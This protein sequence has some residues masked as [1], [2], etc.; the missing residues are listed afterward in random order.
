[1]HSLEKKNAELTDAKERALSA[2]RMKDLFIQNMSH[3]IRTPLNSI[4]GFSQLLATPDMELSPEEQQEY[5]RLITCNSE[6]L[7]TLVNDI[8]GVAELESGN[9]SIHMDRVRCNELCRN[10]LVTVSHRKPAGVELTFT[11]EADDGYTLHTDGKRVSQVLINFLT[12]AEKHTVKGTIGLH[13]SLSERPGSITFSVSDTGCG[14]PPEEAEHIFERFRKLD[15]FQQ[16]SGLG[17]SICRLIAKQM[18]GSVELD[19]GYTG[20]ARFLFVLPLPSGMPQ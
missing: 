4:V 15:D 7:S 10:A 19:T 5:S 14:I 11:S 16:G 8:L 1:M 17:L 13:V 12:N 2:S 9:V 20:G 3:E 18:Q 6:L